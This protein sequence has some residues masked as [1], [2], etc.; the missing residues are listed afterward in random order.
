M[1]FSYCE[2]SEKSYKENVILMSLGIV[3]KSEGVRAACHEGS[4]D[5]AMPGAGRRRGPGR[6]EKGF[7]YNCT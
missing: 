4:I 7:I 2:N 1:H 3:A 5:V 6:S